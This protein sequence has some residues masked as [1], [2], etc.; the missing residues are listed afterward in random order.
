[1]FPFPALAI[2]AGRAPLGGPREIVLACFLVAR[3]V[4][5]AT[6]TSAV[7]SPNQ[8]NT[9]AQGARH[10]LGSAAIPTQVRSALSRLAESTGGED[11]GAIK[12]ALDSVMTVTANHLDSRARLELGRLA[13]AIA[14]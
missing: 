10:W 14:E 1:V 3:M 5:D 2:M 13:Q 4:S 8:K 7:L 12:A 9:R 11:R 6:Q